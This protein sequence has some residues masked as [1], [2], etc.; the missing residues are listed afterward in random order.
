MLIMFSY[1]RL[2]VMTKIP[3]NF[4]Q[5]IVRNYLIIL[6]ARIY[7]KNIFQML[8]IKKFFRESITIIYNLL[9]D[10]FKF[11]LQ[12]SNIFVML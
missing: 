10:L 9:E 6:N 8:H 4:T 12:Q 5:K 7:Y 3:P 1:F 11:N 2:I